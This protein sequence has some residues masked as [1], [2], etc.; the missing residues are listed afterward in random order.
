MAVRKPFSELQFSDAFMF[1]AA[2]EDEEICRGVLERILGIP[3]RKVRVRTEDSLLVNPDYRSI[4]MDVYANNEEGTVFDVEMQTTDHRNLPER[5]RAYQG[6]MDMA[7]L[8]PGDEFT[9]LPVSYIIFICTYDPFGFGRYRYTYEMRC[10]ET[11]DSLG[12]RTYRV[13][14]NTKGTDTGDIPPELIRFLR[15]VGE[16]P[17]GGETDTDSLIN[18]IETR[19]REL[20]GNR[21][22]EVNYMLFGEMLNDER[23]EGRMEGHEEG[24]KEGLEKG[25]QEGQARL[26]RLMEAMAEDGHAQQLPILGKDPQFLEEMYQKYH[27]EA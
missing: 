20:K 1:A 24:F 9:G 21:G 23:R 25:F 2:M 5:S 27:I 26:F 22:M 17:Q 16:I 7:A 10:R 18:R 19:I 14:L 4:R 12:D 13:F 11:G 6:Q 3:I 8:K 15:Y